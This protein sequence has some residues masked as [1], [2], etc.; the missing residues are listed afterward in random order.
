MK[1][2]SPRE[3][4]EAVSNPHTSVAHLKYCG[5]CAERLAALKEIESASENARFG[6]AES[7]EECYP[8]MELAEYLRGGDERRSEIKTHLER[9][10]ACFE[11]AAYYYSESE[12]MWAAEVKTP[13]KYRRAALDLVPAENWWRK[14]IIVPLPAYATALTLWAVM[15]LTP[16]VARVVLV[17]ESAFFTLFEKRFDTMPYF[18]F[19]GEGEKVGSQ[20]S[21]M[22]IISTRGEMTFRW[23]PVDGADSYYVLLQE[24]VD[25]VPAK[26]REMETTRPTVTLPSDGFKPDATYRW[27]AAGSVAENRYFQGKMEFRIATD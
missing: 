11:A 20:L 6:A 17:K 3:L 15:L 5:V 10:D 19:S 21:G 23:N 27:I 25:G 2:L 1:H 7:T 13:E 18:Y 24:I 22:R 8:T 4:L 9:C 14:W 12:L 26:I 16:S